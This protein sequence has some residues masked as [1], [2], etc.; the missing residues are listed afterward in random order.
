VA[1]TRPKCERKGVGKP[2]AATMMVAWE[3]SSG[4]TWRYSCDTHAETFGGPNYVAAR[5]EGV[6]DNNSN[7]QPAPLIN[8]PDPPAARGAESVRSENSLANGETVPL[9]DAAFAGPLDS[10]RK[11]L[12]RATCVDPECGNAAPYTGAWCDSCQSRWED[13]QRAKAAAAA[14]EGRPRANNRRRGF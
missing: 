6:V 10:E 11:P 8:R 9:P 12:P 5:L 14:A 4:R 7:A 13:E 3:L 2:H 1:V